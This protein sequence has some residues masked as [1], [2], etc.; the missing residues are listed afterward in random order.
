MWLNDKEEQIF[1]PFSK[2]I[3]S[4]QDKK[5]RF[6]YDNGIELIV[7]FFAEYESENGLE[8]NEE[9]YEEYWEMAFKILEIIKDDKNTNEVGKYILVNYHSI[10][11][12]YEIAK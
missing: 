10:P 2:F 3:E 6:V 4:H 12:K 1:G 8:I 5:F 7:E 9:G 11:Q